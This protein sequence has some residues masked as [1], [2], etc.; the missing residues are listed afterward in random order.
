MPT[1]SRRSKK[2]LNEELD[3]R[4]QLI[5]NEAIKIYDFTI[6]EGRRDMLT[7][8]KLYQEGKSKLRYPE[9]KHN[10][11]PSKAVDIAPYPIRWDDLPRFYYLAGIIKAIAHTRGIA[12]RWG[13]DWDSDGDFRDNRF[14]DLVHFELI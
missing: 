9:S 6:L 3:T 7:Q 8:N 4:L 1:F 10:S 2:I 5:L 12:I 14:N 11:D 13:G